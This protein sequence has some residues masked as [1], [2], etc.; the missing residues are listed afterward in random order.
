MIKYFNRK[1]K[2]NRICLL[3]TNKMILTKKYT[4]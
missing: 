4:A 2:N 1:D 3:S